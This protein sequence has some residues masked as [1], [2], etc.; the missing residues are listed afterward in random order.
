MPGIP[1]L[2]PHR[3]HRN[4]TLSRRSTTCYIHRPQVYST[5]HPLPHP[6][7]IPP[8]LPHGTGKLPRVPRRR[9]FYSSVDHHHGSVIQRSVV[10]HGDEVPRFEGAVL[11]RRRPRDL[12]VARQPLQVSHH[13]AVIVILLEKETKERT[14]P[15]KRTNE[16]TR[17]SG[18]HTSKQTRHTIA[19]T[20]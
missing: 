15:R 13:P 10:H 14:Q 8:S 17:R 1:R 4:S 20:Q 16:R 6:L 3:T 19:G 2:T 7:P 9:V 12:C 5:L 11:W 18:K